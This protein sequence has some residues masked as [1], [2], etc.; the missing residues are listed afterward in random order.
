MKI[1]LTCILYFLVIPNSLCAQEYKKLVWSDEF[2]YEGLP[3]RSKWGYEKGYVRNG[4]KQFYN[5]ADL[6]NSR[7]KNGNLIIEA[8]KSEGNSSGLWAELF[9][10]K[11]PLYT[12]ASLTTRKLNSWTYARIEVRAKLPHGVG[13]WPAIWLLG[14]DEQHQG[15]PAKGEIDL[16]E[17][18]GYKKNKVHVALHT[19]KR[20]HQNKKGINKEFKLEDLLTD[21]HTY[22]VEKYPN[23]IKFYIDN[24]LVF[25]YEKE[26]NSSDY[27]PFDEPMYLIINLAIGGSWGGKQGI[28]DGIF[29][30]QFLIDYVR[31]YQ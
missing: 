10:A 7:V 17:Y 29:P 3:D 9:E 1:I 18:V 16:M 13:V 2:N 19:K 28:D 25:S 20:N 23:I 8:R 22:A 31:V 6:D 27:W 15:W 14:V 21:Y 12:S 5:V 4:E 11:K 30:Q 26:G 24:K